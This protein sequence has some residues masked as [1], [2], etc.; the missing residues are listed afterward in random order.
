MGITAS[1]SSRE[2]QLSEMSQKMLIVLATTI[3][4]LHL[5][6]NVAG[7]TPSKTLLV[8]TKDSAEIEPE[9]ESQWMCYGDAYADYAGGKGNCRCNN[10]D[11]VYPRCEEVPNPKC[12][13][14]RKNNGDCFLQ[15]DKCTA[16]AKTE[17]PILAATSRRR[18][19]LQA[20]TQ[21][22]NNAAG[23]NRLRFV[24]KTYF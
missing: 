2:S 8:T 21:T 11:R 5:S 13:E 22:G 4:A 15:V 9:P 16:Y 20:G 19:I 23:K 1:P 14:C 12:Q 3:V 10:K 24:T 6:Q 17:A 18:R 7:L